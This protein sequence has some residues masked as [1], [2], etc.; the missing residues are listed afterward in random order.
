MKLLQVP[1]AQL[2]DRIKEELE[3]NPALEITAEDE[4]EQ[5]E[6]QLDTPLPEVSDGEENDQEIET[7]TSIDDEFDMTDFYDESDEG[8]AE[9]KTRDYSDFTDPDDENKSIPVASLMTFHEYLEE[10]LGL[11]ELDGKEYEIGLHLIGCLLYTSR[12]V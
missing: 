8:V 10:Q 4:F 3:V 7:E 12:C 9:Y 5:K 2:D 6:D 11:M 1:T